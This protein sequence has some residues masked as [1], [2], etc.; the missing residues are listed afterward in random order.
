MSRTSARALPIGVAISTLL[1]LAA[2]KVAVDRASLDVQ[3]TAL[4]VQFESH[5]AAEEPELALAVLEQMSQLDPDYPPL[6]V[7]AAKLLDSRQELADAGALFATFGS[8]G[9]GLRLGQGLVAHLE[10][11]DLD[12]CQALGEALDLYE[13]RGSVA[14]QA[15]AHHALGLALARLSRLAESASEL[16][17]ALPLLEGLGDRSGLAEALCDLGRVEREAGHLAKALAAERR[18]LALRE[19]LQDLAGQG[20]C[21]YEIGAT[22]IRLEDGDAAI[23]AY[24][25]ALELRRASGDKLAQLQTLLDLGRALEQLGKSEQA[26]ETLTQAAALA[27]GV[28]VARREAE[29]WTELGRLRRRRSEMAAARAAFARAIEL[30]RGLGDEAL[31][32]LA[33]RE[34]VTLHLT[35]GE[36]T[37]ALVA[38]ER[39]L[40]I[41]RR[42]GDRA[43]E[44]S[45]LETL[46]VTR[47]RLSDIVT[48]R[49]HFED[50]LGLAQELGDKR[51]E[52]R[53]RSNLGVVLVDL[54]S[55][56]TALEQERTSIALW[57]ALG[58]ERGLALARFNAADVLWR[59]GRHNEAPAELGQAQASFLALADREGEASTLNLLADFHL[60][61]GRRDDALAAFA[62]SLELCERYGLARQEWAARVGRGTL[63]EQAGQPQAAL[64]DYRRA[65][66]IVE[67]PRGRTETS[68]LKL[69]ALPARLDRELYERAMALEER[70]EEP[71]APETF[72][73]GERAKAHRLLDLL[74]EALAGLGAG[75][76]EELRAREIEAL[77]AIDALAAR[78]AAADPS[79]AA[80]ARSDL[81]AAEERLRLLQAELLERSPSYGQLVHPR[82]AQ[83]WEVR[84]ELGPDE[85]L[86]S[87]FI[88][89]G[90]AWVWIVE[91]HAARLE[92]LRP[93]GEIRGLVTAFLAAAG[94]PSLRAEGTAPG[95][96]EAEAL[97]RAVLPGGLR[98]GRRL[99]VAPSGLLHHVPFAALRRG[100]RWLVQ[101]HEI[102]VVPSATTLGVMR[103]HPLSTAARGFF[104]GGA[105]RLADESPAGALADERQMLES[106]AALFPAGESDLLLGERFSR[107]ALSSRPLGERRYLH[108]ATRGWLD[109]ESPRRFGLR[110]SDPPEGGPGEFLHLDDVAG[111]RLAA[112]L[113]VLPPCDT[114]PE[115]LRRGDGLVSLTR[116]FLAAGAGSV[117][118]T[119]WSVDERATAEFM[120]ALY[121]ELLEGRSLPDAVCRVQRASIASERPALRQPHRWAPFVLVQGAAPA[122]EEP[123]EP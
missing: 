100:G 38:G 62:R 40:E 93:P 71:S 17:A 22:L 36:L 14:G 106:L 101:E 111:S 98:E 21:W 25:R 109:P 117:L 16:E 107:S 118:A 120:E 83:L 30:A 3:L 82:P 12:A 29:A 108:L 85:T 76:P 64:A 54:G 50:A 45:V 61:E 31:E 47:H 4:Q 18:A 5:W 1:A 13:E 46:G 6:Y 110:L 53:A 87:Y 104:G 73:L 2:G 19:A 86:L 78:R 39:A 103:R 121:R 26:V 88:G 92:R 24:E 34:A 10:R 41:D 114:S 72:A 115:E 63:L 20:Q 105:P 94:R 74:A 43:G 91:R 49:R 52:A 11:R 89:D 48:A 95:T 8:R 67:T 80:D 60:E 84:R 37:L 44:L 66:D 77:D 99:L 68:E 97:S 79:E 65:L 123:G 15:T 75:L 23:A 55:F 96:R 32:A 56:L 7:S 81:D 35:T 122:P 42:L 57:Q 59:L 51:A 58:E 28:G 102:V 116:G 9:P 70:I 33:L 119:L 112:E 113:V 69:R 90:Q 27:R